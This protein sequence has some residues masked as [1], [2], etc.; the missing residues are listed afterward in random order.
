[1]LKSSKSQHLTIYG[2]G[3]NLS[4]RAPTLIPLTFNSQ[5]RYSATQ[6]ASQTYPPSLLPSKQKYPT[7]FCTLSTSLYPLQSQWFHVCLCAD[8][9]T[10]S[11]TNYKQYFWRSNCS[12]TL[13]LATSSL[14]S[15]LQEYRDRSKHKPYRNKINIKKPSLMVIPSAEVSTNFPFI[16]SLCSKLLSDIPE[17]GLSFQLGPNHK[18][19]AMQ[20]HPNLR[21]LCCCW[22]DFKFS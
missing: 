7:A 3:E 20:P 17:L 18:E 16:L 13:Q 19:K 10:P 22:K 5:F 21:T 8:W 2:G 15:L 14:I 12:L 9:E 1:M 6:E 11:R 4:L